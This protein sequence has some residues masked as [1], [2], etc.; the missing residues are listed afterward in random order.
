ML[1]LHNP[2]PSRQ[3]ALHRPCPLALFRTISLVR[4]DAWGTAALGGDPSRGRL[5]YMRCPFDRSRVSPYG[6]PTNG[7]RRP[8]LALFHTTGCPRAIA[9]KLAGP[10]FWAGNADRSAW[11]PTTTS[12]RPLRD[13]CFRG[14]DGRFEFRCVRPAGCP[15][16]V[17]RPG[18]L[19]LFCAIVRCLWVGNWLCLARSSPFVVTPHTVPGK[20]EVRWLIVD[21][22]I[23]NHTSTI[24]LSLTP[25]RAH[26]NRPLQTRHSRLAIQLFH[27]HTCT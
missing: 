14:Q 21:L 26:R 24:L 11:S 5:G 7:S 17:D 19:G 25:S 23:K 22:E 12:S 4:G 10:C 16:L 9:S 2:F 20:F 13:Q 15:L 1:F 27:D 8:P 18:K 6:H 3:L